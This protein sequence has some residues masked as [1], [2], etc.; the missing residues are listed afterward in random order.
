LRRFT[1]NKVQGKTLD[2]AR[3]YLPQPVFSG[4][5]LYVAVSKVIFFEKLKMQIILNNKKETMNIV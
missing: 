2:K 1:I 3:L 5:Q 4:G